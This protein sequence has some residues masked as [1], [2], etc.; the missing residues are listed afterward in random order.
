MAKKAT[1]DKAQK[2]TV[3]ATENKKATR[4]AATVKNNNK[5]EKTMKKN[6]K[7]DE[8]KAARRQMIANEEKNY[9]E[10]REA[11][12][13]ENEVKA[14]AV[15]RDQVK[16][17]KE[18]AKEQQKNVNGQYKAAQK[19]VKDLES[20]PMW[21]FHWLNRTATHGA[22]CK[23]VDFSGA[24]LLAV[25]NHQG[26][27]TPTANSYEGFSYDSV[28]VDQFGRICKVTPY[29]AGQGDEQTT[30]ANG[31][32]MM[33]TKKHPEGVE[34]IDTFV[35][36]YILEPVTINRN[37]ILEAARTK[38]NLYTAVTADL[39]T[40]SGK[41]IRAREER[42]AANRAAE[43]V[44]RYIRIAKKGKELREAAHAVAVTLEELDNL[45]N[46]TDYATVRA[47]LRSAVLALVKADKENDYSGLIERA[48]E[49]IYTPKYGLPTAPANV[50]EM[51]PQETTT[52]APANVVEESP[53]RPWWSKLAAAMF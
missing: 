8:Q 37:N 4:K 49:A 25:Y 26:E 23:D 29:K 30:A 17:D 14:A 40:W 12:L 20:R 22:E 42:E 3:K 19:S 51:T 38:A 35:G 7:A 36:R 10:Q 44:Q 43:Q 27:M 50:V 11:I 34:I 5:N 16:S 21:C 2:A 39:M 9:Q 46:L 28:K 48:N 45:K 13:K 33:M 6:N 31:A 18:S 32:M 53:R 15:T 1:A 47:T 24:E 52:E 41:A